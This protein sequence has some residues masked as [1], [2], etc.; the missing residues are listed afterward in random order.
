LIDVIP[1]WTNRFNSWKR[2]YFAREIRDEGNFF[3]FAKFIFE[4]I[5]NQTS[6]NKIKNTDD[7]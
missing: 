1:C 2:Y 6:A 3:K 5:G 7:I 4:N